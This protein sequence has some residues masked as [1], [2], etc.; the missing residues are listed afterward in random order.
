M[1]FAFENVQSPGAFQKLSEP[2]K[3]TVIQDIPTQ[4]KML[5]SKDQIVDNKLIIN[6]NL[7]INSLKLF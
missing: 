2:V 4:K 6:S 7:Y 1:S 5:S 3:P